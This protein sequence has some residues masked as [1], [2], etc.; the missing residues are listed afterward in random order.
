M[1]LRKFVKNDEAVLGYFLALIFSATM[2]VFLF[3]FAIPFLTA[4]TIDMYAAGDTILANAEDELAN[5]Q[6]ATIRQAIQGNLDNMQAATAENIDY[7]SFFYQ[8]SWIL[9]III[10]TFTIFILARKTVETK[11]YGGVV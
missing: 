6:N 11:G 1:K 3:A 10:V 4:F 9:I 7:L 8:Y 5:I 2:L